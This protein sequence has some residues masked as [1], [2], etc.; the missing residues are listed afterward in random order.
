MRRFPV[1]L[2]S[3]KANEAK[4]LTLEFFLVFPGWHTAKELIRDPVVG[5][6]YSADGTTRAVQMRLMRYSSMGLL[7]RQREQGEYRYAITSKG[8]DRLFFLWGKYGHLD[9]K[10]EGLSAEEMDWMMGR[11]SIIISA[12]ERRLVRIR[13][14]RSQGLKSDQTSPC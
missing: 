9:T 5:S 6:I 2:D 8:E 4:M 11:L 3:P 14:E 13:L 10:K 7:E 1:A 12:L